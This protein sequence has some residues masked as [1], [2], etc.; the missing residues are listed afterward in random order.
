LAKKVRL[1]VSRSDN[2]AQQGFTL[3]EV[4]ISLLIF[5]FGLLGCA[6]LQESA[7]KYMQEA[8]SRSYALNL[9]TIMLGNIG[10]DSQAR[11]CYQLNRLELGVGYEQ[12]FK[13]TSKGSAEAQ[14]HAEDS[15]NFWNELLQGA[16]TTNGQK[17]IGGLLN[18]RGCIAFDSASNSYVVTVVW[19][20]ITQ[21]SPT[22]SN[23]GSAIFGSDGNSYR[24]LVSAALY[25]PNLEG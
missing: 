21:A 23:C 25:V 8:Y 5:S 10:V 1:G 19:Q 16:H 13:C 2:T 24:R 17:Y 4:L 11:D 14:Q 7:Q 22:Y 15:I 9:L 20:G 3:I 18:A 6:S 12:L